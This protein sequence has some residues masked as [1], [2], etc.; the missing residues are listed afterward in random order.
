MATGKSKYSK[1]KNQDDLFCKYCSY[2]AIHYK[3]LNRHD[4]Q[5]HPLEKEHETVHLCEKCDFFT[6]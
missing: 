6:Q 2:K 1:S 3:D 4:L 5:M